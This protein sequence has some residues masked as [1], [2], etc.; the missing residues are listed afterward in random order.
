MATRG[1]ELGSAAAGKAIAEQEDPDRD[2]YRENP[3]QGKE[4]SYLSAGG[5][6]D[7]CRKGCNFS[8]AKEQLLPSGKG[9]VI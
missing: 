7:F 1:R 4:I 6:T 3:R 8:V 9:P 2:D 5:E